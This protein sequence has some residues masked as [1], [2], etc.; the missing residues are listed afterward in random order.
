MASR[1]SKA[2]WLNTG[3]GSMLRCRVCRLGESIDGV[4]ESTFY[5]LAERFDT[6]M[7]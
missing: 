6:C 3:V 2:R 5:F 7:Q 4:W 1:V